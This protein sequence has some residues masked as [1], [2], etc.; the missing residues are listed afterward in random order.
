M[1]VL[2]PDIVVLLP[3]PVIVPGLIVQLP[4]GKPP[5]MTD[6]VANAQVGCVMVPMVGVEG[7]AG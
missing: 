1:L 3:L 2:S 5:R 4:A 6:P 7:V